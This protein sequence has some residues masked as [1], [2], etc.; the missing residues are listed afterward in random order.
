MQL[1]VVA[2]E[3]GERISQLIADVSSIS[4]QLEPTCRVCSGSRRIEREARG[5]KHRKASAHDETAE[6]DDT[7]G[8]QEDEQPDL[9]RKLSKLREMIDEVIEDVEGGVS[10]K[11]RIVIPG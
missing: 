4:Y 7:A 8:S 10:G 6:D 5:G 2:A 3:C 1:G 11:S 9:K